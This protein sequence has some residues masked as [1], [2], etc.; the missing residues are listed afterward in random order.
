MC[1]SKH[2]SL[3]LKSVKD[4]PQSFRELGTGGGQKKGRETRRLYEARTPFIRVYLCVSVW[5][6]QA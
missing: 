6:R 1:L 2:A 5:Q 4:F 3:L